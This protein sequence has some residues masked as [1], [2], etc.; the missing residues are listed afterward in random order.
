[1]TAAIEQR[2]QAD[3]EHIF[4]KAPADVVDGAVKTLAVSPHNPAVVL[5]NASVACAND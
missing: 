2:E 4:G 5:D 3:H 1:M